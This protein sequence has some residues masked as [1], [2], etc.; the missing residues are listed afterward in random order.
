M[1][2]HYKMLGD[3]SSC[4]IN[5]TLNL[6]NEELYLRERN[7]NLIGFIIMKNTPL[8]TTVDI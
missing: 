4:N 5:G 1:Q 3:V 2:F 7:Y 8:V 6:K